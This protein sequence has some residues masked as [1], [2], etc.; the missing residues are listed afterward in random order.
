MDENVIG[1]LIKYLHN[2]F[3]HTINESMTQ[4]NITRSQTDVLAYTYFKNEK[5]IEVNQV[6]IERD[7]HL[8]NPTVTGIVDRLE[9]KGY[10]KREK[11]SKG[12]NY[13]KVVV[14]ESGVKILEDGKKV[15]NQVERGMFSV[16]D[17]SEKEELIRL[18]K[19]VIDNKNLKN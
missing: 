6:D 16:L 9:K 15:V 10:V 5:D 17:E 3:E 11:S 12:N 19:K 4:V 18:I 14:T 7:L 2:M 13:K 1:S 8:K